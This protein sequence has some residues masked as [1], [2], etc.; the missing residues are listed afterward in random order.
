MCNN[1]TNTTRYMSAFHMQWLIISYGKQYWNIKFEMVGKQNLFTV[2]LNYQ[3]EDPFYFRKKF[4]WRK[5]Q[6]YS[7]LWPKLRLRMNYRQ[8]SLPSKKSAITWGVEV[9][10]FAIS[11]WNEVNIIF[12]ARFQLDIL[13]SMGQARW[14]FQDRPKYMI[15]LDT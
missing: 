10:L 13:N 11:H 14:I 4:V 9:H 5:F 7:Q 12:I 15:Q 6:I 1:G 3:N 8:T 2:C